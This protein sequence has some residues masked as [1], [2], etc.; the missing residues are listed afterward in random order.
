MQNYDFSLIIR[1]FAQRTS[2]ILL[3]GIV[4]VRRT[5]PCRVDIERHISILNLGIVKNGVA[6]TRKEI[7]FLVYGLAYASVLDRLQNTW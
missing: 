7:R 2:Q 6:H 3:S 5:K 4:P 1:K